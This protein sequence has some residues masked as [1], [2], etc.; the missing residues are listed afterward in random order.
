MAH[1]YAFVGKLQNLSGMEK[2]LSETSESFLEECK[3]LGG[4]YKML[5]LPYSKIPTPFLS[6]VL[7]YY[8]PDSNT[9]NIKGHVLGV[10]LQDM[11]FLARIRIDGKPVL[12]KEYNDD[13]CIS[14][15]GK[16]M[17]EFD[18]LKAIIED[19]G[20]DA[21][22][23]KVA[24]LMLI[25]N[26]IIMPSHNGNRFYPAFFELLSDP[27]ETSMTYA[28]KAAMLAALQH[29]LQKR[30]NKVGGCAWL[31]VCFFFVRIP[32]L[33]DSIGLTSVREEM[34][35]GQLAQDPFPMKWILR[36]LQLSTFGKDQKG[37]YLKTISPVF[38]NLEDEIWS[39]LTSTFDQT[40]LFLAFQI[41]YMAATTTALHTD[42]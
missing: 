30:Y 29:H 38:E 33:W 25:V 5:S 37:G 36:K 34:E 21:K 27:D 7:E 40:R 15:F 14:I 16:A 12:V 6:K 32:K 9:F 31:L 23:R 10:T 35:E 13:H 20:S 2:H 17:Y 42:F 8:N 28:W 41:P 4:L 39:Q 24:L 19:T 3:A 18:E 26:S 1:R 11:L 22:K